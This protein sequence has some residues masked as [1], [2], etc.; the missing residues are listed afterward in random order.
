MGHSHLLRSPTLVQSFDQRASM[1]SAAVPEAWQ[2][3]RVP[4]IFQ[5]SPSSQIPSL[6]DG[7][8]ALV[9]A[10]ALNPA[11]VDQPGAIALRT[12]DAVGAG[13]TP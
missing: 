8:Q 10:T 13:P 3:D 4:D 12:K 2:L 9:T 5:I 7:L 6:P 1:I 11:H